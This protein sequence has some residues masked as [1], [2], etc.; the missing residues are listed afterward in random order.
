ME[1]T[2]LLPTS[3]SPSVVGITDFLNSKP[4]ALRPRHGSK[5]KTEFTSEQVESLQQ[6]IKARRGSSLAGAVGNFTKGLMGAGI[7]SIP[8]AFG[9]AGEYLSLVS[10]PIISVIVYITMM[11]LVAVFALQSFIHYFFFSFFVFLSSPSHNLRQNTK[12]MNNTRE[13]GTT[14]LSSHISILEKLH[15]QSLNM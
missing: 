3:T 13:I 14:A 5:L 8:Y 1:S 7:L 9:E 2:P 11:L 10:A 4:A 15:I 6:T 12:P